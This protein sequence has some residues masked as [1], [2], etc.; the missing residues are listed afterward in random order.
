MSFF[1][2][3]ELRLIQICISAKDNATRRATAHLRCF[4]LKFA[5][6]RSATLAEARANYR[7]RRQSQAK[8]R[9]LRAV[10]AK[11]SEDGRKCNA[12]E[13]HAKFDALPN[14]FT[15]ATTY[16]NQEEGGNY[17]CLKARID[18]LERLRL[19]S[20]PL[21]DIV[22]VR[23]PD[24]SRDYAAFILRSFGKHTGVKFIS[25]INDV[26]KRLDSH[27]TNAPKGIVGCNPDAFLRFVEIMWKQAPRVA[28]VIER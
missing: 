28:T 8:E 23:L 16:Q 7:E 11:A 5:R 27:F 13:L 18:F 6:A 2:D 1:A 14:T 19:R 12:L 9:L 24:L 25:R 4:V 20:P 15:S 22:A 3:K 21:P 26:L 10:E 17:T